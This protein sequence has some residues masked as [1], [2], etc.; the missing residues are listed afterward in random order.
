M[1]GRCGGDAVLVS[2]RARYGQGR[3]PRICQKSHV[4][5]HDSTAEKGWRARHCHRNFI[6]Q[7]DRQNV[8]LT[9]R[10]G[11]LSPCVHHSN[12]HCQRELDTDCVEHAVRVM[13]DADPDATILSIDGV[14]VYDHVLCSV[15]MNKLHKCARL[16]RVVAFRQVHTCPS[17]QGT[18]GRTLKVAGTRFTRK[19]A[20]NKGFRLCLFCS[21]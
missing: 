16:E 11:V 8:G 20:E 17:Q 5:D 15:V 10:E 4:G 12:S 7:V 18:R 21:A 9:V 2:C 14:G 3:R 19:S 13:T 1:S 6:P